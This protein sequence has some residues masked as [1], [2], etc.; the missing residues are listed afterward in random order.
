MKT[1]GFV[2]V[3]G[4]NIPF[5]ATTTQRNRLYEFI[6]SHCGGHVYLDVLKSVHN[7]LVHGLR[8]CASV[9]VSGALVPLP[10]RNVTSLSDKCFSVTAELR[11]CTPLMCLR[12]ALWPSNFESRLKYLSCIF[13]SWPS[14]HVVSLYRGLFLFRC[15][16]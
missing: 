12:F 4:T 1:R 2:T 16:A 9:R 15:H 5:A 7:S 14:R 11:H 3:Q 10:L 6:R 13:V 8:S